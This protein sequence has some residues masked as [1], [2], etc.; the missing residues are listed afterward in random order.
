MRPCLHVFERFCVN[1]H[2]IYT[3]NFCMHLERDYCLLIGKIDSFCHTI[4]YSSFFPYLCILT[5]SH[6]AGHSV[7]CYRVRSWEIFSLRKKVVFNT[8]IVIFKSSHAYSVLILLATS[9]MDEVAY[10]I[11]FKNYKVLHGSRYNIL[12]VLYNLL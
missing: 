9:Y 2:N 11:C 8:V 6:E 7:G 3:V 5:R 10:N 1:Q 4:V 12:Q